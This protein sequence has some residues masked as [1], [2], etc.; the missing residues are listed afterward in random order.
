MGK[1]AEAEKL[2]LIIQQPDL[3]IS[4]YKNNRQYDQVK[5]IR[6][7]LPVAYPILIL[8]I[9]IMIR[10]EQKKNYFSYSCC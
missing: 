3:A 5:K 2:Y 6:T 4:M 7:L 8:N 1:L 9:Y 10:V